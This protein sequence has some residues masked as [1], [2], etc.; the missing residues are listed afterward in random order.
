GTLVVR[1]R[2]DEIGRLA[3]A[4]MQMQASLRERIAAE[5]DAALANQRV[6]QALDVARAAVL[7][8][9]GD[10]RVVYANDALRQT[11]AQ[12]GVETPIATGADAATLGAEVA[13][14]LAEA[15]GGST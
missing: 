3:A 14:V 11:F 8:T 5:R 9:D 13:A 1:N 2:D 15:E 6:R 10:G 4:L 7:V 12:A